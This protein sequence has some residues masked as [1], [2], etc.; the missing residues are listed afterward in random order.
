MVYLVDSA[1]Q[2]KVWLVQNLKTPKP[3]EDVIQTLKPIFQFM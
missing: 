3:F 2:I 1:S